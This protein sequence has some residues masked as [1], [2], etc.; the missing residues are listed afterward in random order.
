MVVNAS[1]MKKVKNLDETQKTK[2]E[3]LTHLAL[4]TLLQ[5]LSEL[6]CPKKKKKQNTDVCSFHKYENLCYMSMCRC[7]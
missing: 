1:K 5:P 6:D 4:L 7:N 3:R 2:N